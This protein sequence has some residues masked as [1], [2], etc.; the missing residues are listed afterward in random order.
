MRA[1]GRRCSSRAEEVELLSQPLLSASERRLSASELL[2]ASPNQRVAL[3]HAAFQ[4]S[5]GLPK[6]RAGAGRLF[7]AQDLRKPCAACNE[8]SPK[9]EP[10]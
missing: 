4:L 3:A 6:R 8:L 7:E 5:D 1:L 2:I 10:K 9:E